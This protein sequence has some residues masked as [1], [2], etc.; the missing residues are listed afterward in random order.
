MPKYN[1]VSGNFQLLSARACLKDAICQMYFTICGR[2]SQNKGRIAGYVTRIWRKYHAKW[3]MQMA[4]MIFQTRSI[5][6]ANRFE[7]VW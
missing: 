4:G 2:F 1:T 6:T 5:T 7:V 3:G